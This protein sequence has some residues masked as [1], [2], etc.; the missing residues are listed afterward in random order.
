MTTTMHPETN[1]RT[2]KTLASQIDR[3]DSILDGLADAIDSNP[4]AIWLTHGHLDHAGGPAELKEKL[5][6]VPIE[7]PHIA[8]KFL[9]D[10]SDF[11][12]DHPKGRM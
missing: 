9:L 11:I 6:G 7:G 4:D 5:G 2:R 3:L 1:G 12:D 8:D 10:V